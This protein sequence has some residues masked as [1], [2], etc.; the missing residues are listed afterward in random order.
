VA[1]IIGHIAVGMIAGRAYTSGRSDARPWKAMVALSVASVLPD[2]DVLAFSFGIPYHAPYGHRGAFHSLSISVLLG[3]LVWLLTLRSTLPALRT[4]V[5]VALMAAS[6][7]L[8]DAFTDGGLG[9]AL[10]WPFTNVRYLARWR[11]IP[12]APMGRHFL[13]RQGAYVVAIEL[14]YFAP[15]M[16]LAV[17]RRGHPGKGETA[18]KKK[19]KSNR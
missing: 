4:G 8:I 6:H 10:L 18:S 16:I 17:W 15:L 13:S 9:V 14:L 5:Y 12:A 19:E 11:P 3:V 2:L 7:S 1:S